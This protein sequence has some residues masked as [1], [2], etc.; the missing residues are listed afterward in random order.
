MSA[1]YGRLRGNRGEV[2]RTAA[3]E[4]TATLETWEGKVC[5]TLWKDGAYMVEVVEVGEKY[6]SMERVHE[7][8]V[9]ERSI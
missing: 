8:N 1:L 5:V 9:E 3:C 2:T 4:I 7:G 6:G